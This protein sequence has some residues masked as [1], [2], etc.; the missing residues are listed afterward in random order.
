MSTEAEKSAEER[1]AQ[2]KKASEGL[3]QMMQA[4]G[5]QDLDL[6]KVDTNDTGALFQAIFDVIFKDFDLSGLFGG[7]FNKKSEVDNRSPKEKLVEGFFQDIANSSFTAEFTGDYNQVRAVLAQNLTT[8]LND[9]TIAI[10]EGKDKNAFIAEAIEAIPEEDI[11]NA[12]RQDMA[13]DLQEVV[14]KYG[15]QIRVAVDAPGAEV[16]AATRDEDVSVTTSP[17][18]LEHT[19]SVT[20]VSD[21]DLES[22][23]YT[24]GVKVPLAAPEF[25]D[26]E[27]MVTT[28]SVE[29]GNLVENGNVPTSTFTNGDVA[30]ITKTSTGDPV[31]LYYTNDTGS[32]VMPIGSGDPNQGTIVLND[33]LV[34]SLTAPVPQPA[35]A[36]TGPV[37][38]MQNDNT[39][40]LDPRM[41]GMA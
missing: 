4:F 19:E 36:P 9:G 11:I 3:N 34:A 31:G 25:P 12:N 22:N 21:A 30:L 32:H 40:K 14:N 18:D 41:G 24:V 10:P 15:G 28:Y 27:S 20:T 33:G 8:M 5:M 7:L 6:S 16:P 38:T 26:D 23:G 35:P 37:V 1:A 13:A 29:N 17:D 39:M 2:Q